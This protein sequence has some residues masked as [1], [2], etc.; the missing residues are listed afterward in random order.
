MS[1]MRVEGGEV[2]PPQP[3]QSSVKIVRYSPQGT[4]SFFLFWF[5]SANEIIFFSP[6]LC[7]FFVSL[8]LTTTPPG[9]FRDSGG[10]RKTGQKKWHKSSIVIH[11]SVVAPSA[12]VSTSSLRT[13]RLEGGPLSLCF[14][15]V[16]I[17]LLQAIFVMI[18]SGFGGED[19]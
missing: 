13:P 1:T 17:R 4:N 9:R 3:G 2:T 5:S 8:R 16:F 19:G 11:G 12:T 10:F 6:Q 7:L 18:V 15:V 14:M